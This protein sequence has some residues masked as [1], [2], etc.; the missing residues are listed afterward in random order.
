MRRSNLPMAP[1]ALLSAVLVVAV[2]G[3]GSNDSSSPVASAAS[4]SAASAT[5]KV[6]DL[7]P[8]NDSVPC[9]I[10]A[11]THTLGPRQVMA[12]LTLTLPPGWQSPEANP[13]N[14]VFLAP[15][16]PDERLILLGGVSAVQ[17]TGPGAG[18]TVLD[19]VGKTPDALVEWLTTNPDFAVVDGPAQ[20]KIGPDT[21]A[22]A[23]TVGVSP[24]ARYGDPGCP[25]N[26]RCADLF[27]LGG[28][29]YGIGGHEQIRL[30]LAEDA[31]Y[32][33]A[34]FIV[35]LEAPNHRALTHLTELATPVIGSM[36]P[37]AS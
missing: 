10:E 20:V 25:A 8:C 14:V 35:A 26:P 17:S 36:Q 6:L 22:V 13:A 23:L 15:G 18:T 30:Y 24:K 3:C 7:T 28:D 37:S 34:A 16:H 12:G 5:P 29:F 2:T 1:R 9:Q 27:S 21:S 31:A 32:P 11:G 19:Q 4:A 33:D